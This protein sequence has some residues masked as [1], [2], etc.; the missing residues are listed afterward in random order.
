MRGRS[1]RTV[2]AALGGLLLLS[3]PILCSAQQATGG[4]PV[5]PIGRVAAF[6]PGSIQGIVRDE[7]G[8]PVAGA[9]VSVIGATTAVAVTDR[10]G[11]FELQSLT[12][13][14]YLVRAHLSG[15]AA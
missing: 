10:N 13:G 11:R 3:T 12:P 6:A 15:Y 8:I 2:S 9:T 7:T 4:W 5:R 14:P 1:R